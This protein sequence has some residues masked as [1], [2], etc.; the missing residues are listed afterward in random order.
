MFGVMKVLGRML[1]PGRI[2]ATNVATFEAKPQVDPCVS[3][4]DAVLTDVFV[5]DREFHPIEMSA[6]SHRILQRFAFSNA[7]NRTNYSSANVR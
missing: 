1:I 7:Q 3:S 4:F 2:A 6:L 5:C